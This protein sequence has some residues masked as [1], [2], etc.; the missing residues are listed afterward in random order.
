MK[1]CT[2]HYHDLTLDRNISQALQ[3]KVILTQKARG[4]YSLSNSGTE[5]APRVK[6]PPSS[7]LTYKNGK[8]IW[9][10]LSRILPQNCPE[11]LTR[12]KLGYFARPCPITPRH[13]F[14]ESRPVN[15]IEEAQKV[16]EEARLVDPQAEVIVTPR[17]SG[18][19][20]G[21]A[22]NAGVTWGFAND[23]VTSGGKG[24]TYFIPAPALKE[25][26][27]KVMLKY[28]EEIAGD[29]K[30]TVYVEL[31][32]H[33]NVVHAVQLRDGPEQ[34]I[35]KNYIPRRTTVNAVLTPN[36]MDLLTWEK[37]LQDRVAKD[38]NKDWIVYFPGALSSHYAVHAISL[39]V[40]VVTDDAFIKVGTVLEP[41]AVSVP[42]LTEADTRELALL[43]RK[44]YRKKVF[45]I[46]TGDGNKQFDYD[47]SREV[48]A[49]IS[50]AIHAMPN[51]G[52]EPH[53]MRLRALAMAL[54][55][56][57]I[58]SATMGEVR[59]WGIAGPGR[60]KRKRKSRSFRRRMFIALNR[61]DQIYKA[62]LNGGHT[63]KQQIAHMEKLAEDFNTP[64]WGSRYG[65]RSAYGGKRWGDVALAG[66]RMAKELQAFLERPTVNGWHKL[67]MAANNALHTV[68]NNGQSFNKW[69][70]GHWLDRIALAPSVGFMNAYAARAVLDLELNVRPIKRRIELE[71]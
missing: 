68:H 63:L 5:L 54:M 37:Y 66:I 32:S 23:G 47:S 6:L 4:F 9:K 19:Y 43:I 3:D 41:P 45:S 71:R 65:T 21:I 22:T 50:A 20:S 59:H 24:N 26:W 16:L 70:G 28:K 18:E 57:F 12:K 13:G 69:I 10:S 55:P 51:W 42:V 67:V 11:P 39:G 27:N 61:R 8:S 46:N 48:I 52:N 29:I 60:Y 56:R 36:G 31:V 38:G 33:N 35:Q 44:Y 15:T 64:G 40:A 34:S 17:L 7:I 58:L 62:G 49:T 30:D 2:E 53:L 1:N 25:Q 14:V